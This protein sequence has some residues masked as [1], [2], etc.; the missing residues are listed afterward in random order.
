MK[1]KDLSL[2]PV[3][4]KNMLIGN[5]RIITH[6]TEINRNYV[7]ERFFVHIYYIY[8]F[9]GEVICYKGVCNDFMGM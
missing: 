4:I 3:H 5:N 9:C 1:F 7:E 8:V 6:L 2:Q